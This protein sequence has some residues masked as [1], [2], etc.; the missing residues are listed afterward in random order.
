MQRA[1]KATT[2]DLIRNKMSYAV[3][4]LGVALSTQVHKAPVAAPGMRSTVSA[5]VVPRI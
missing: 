5:T 3:T 4:V 2:S 1:P